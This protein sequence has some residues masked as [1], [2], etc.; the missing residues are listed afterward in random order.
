MECQILFSNKNKKKYF[1]MSAEIFVQYAK[2]KIK[3]A[4]QLLNLYHS[5]G[6]FNRQQTYDIFLIFFQKTASI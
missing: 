5:L 1:K 3:C 4:V 2:L 6:K